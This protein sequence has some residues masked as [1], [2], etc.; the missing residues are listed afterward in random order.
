MSD[1]Q[2]VRPAG[3][4]R[5]RLLA[6]SL[7]LILVVAGLVLCWTT[8]TRDGGDRLFRG[9]PESEW[10]RNLKYSD[11]EQVKQWRAYGEEGV[12]VLIRGLK[13]ANHPSEQ[14]YRRLSRSLP[15]PIRRC[16]PAPKLDLTQSTRQCLVSLLSSLG[17]AASN[18][19][20][21]M[22]WTVRKDESDSVR[23]SAL[24]YFNTS[25]DEN[26]L[27]NKLPAAQKAALLP[28]LLDAMQNSADWGLRNNA[29]LALRYYADQRSSV[30]PVLVNAL[31]D[32]E[33]HVRLLAAEA[34]N[35][36][37]PQGASKAGT[38]AI[39][40]AITKNPDD[41]IASRAVAALGRRGSQPDLAVP[42][43]V[44]SLRSTNTL[45]ACQAVWVLEWSAREFQLYSNAIVPALSSAAQRK[46]NVGNYARNALARWTVKSGRTSEPP[47]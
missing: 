33:P 5:R 24:C 22:I 23:Q 18:A 10:I 14:T 4:R 3:I 1:V 20:P 2:K 39:L 35:R 15:A 26:C 41:Q 21:V 44:E 34:L 25:E 28:P 17:A 11:D 9:K 31:Q 43:L 19:T 29:A 46:D 40:V 8:R 27:L 37:D 42:A 7:I 47:K 45:V 12:Q 30:A 6:A 38:T 32:P 16:L 13:R 36:V